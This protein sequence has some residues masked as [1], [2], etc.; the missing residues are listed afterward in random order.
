M[1]KTLKQ[2][3]QESR[4]TKLSADEKSFIKSALLAHVR[5]EEAVRQ[6]VYRSNIQKQS[7][8]LLFIKPMP[9][10]IAI[11]LALGGGTSLAAQNALP[12]DVLYSVKV[13]VNEEVRGLASLS[14]ESKANWETVLANRRLAEAEELAAESKLDVKARADLE[15]RFE[16]HA[17]KA[18]ARI[19]KLADVD[20]KA[21]AD[22][23]AN[24]QTSLQAHDRIL[25][26]IGTSVD[27]EDEKQIKVLSTKV[28]SEVKDALENRLKSETEVKADVKV[29]VEAAAQGRLNAA[30][31]KVA[32]VRKFID[33]KRDDLGAS[34]AAQAETQ[35]KVAADLIVQG[36]AQLDAKAY[37]QAFTLFGQAHAKA[38]EVK[39]LVTAKA[40]FED[41]DDASPSPSPTSSPKATSSPSASVNVESKTQ[42]EREQT[43]SSSKVRID[44]GL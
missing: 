28:K 33:N 19:E 12:G 24:L 32:E 27:G 11:L 22:I 36:K 35:L 7:F 34:A 42:V 30:E 25:L 18:E 15:A 14:D 21:A 29:N 10:I 2:L 17:N 3:F 4:S 8:N 5:N 26:N 39:M 9:I 6:H 1:Y 43:R 23:A 44:L 40:H 16:E 41:G 13:N 37:A 38:Q 20:A 31:N